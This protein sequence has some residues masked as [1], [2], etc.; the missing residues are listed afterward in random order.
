MKAGAASLQLVGS[1]QPYDPPVLIDKGAD[2]FQALTAKGNES[3][4]AF[5][6]L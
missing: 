3:H 1:L 5:P 2:L 4:G 6:I